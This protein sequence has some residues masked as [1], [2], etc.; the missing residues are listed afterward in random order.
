MLFGTGSIDQVA[1]RAP[2]VASLD[3]E[4]LTLPGVSLLRVT[5]EIARRDIQTFFP[6]ALQA[7]VPPLVTW[8]V[9]RCDEGPLGCFQLAET[10]LNCR[11]GA[12]TRTYLLGG[13]IDGEQ[14]ADVLS[15]RWGFDP[16]IG[17]IRLSKAFDR[18]DASVAIE[19]QRI[20]QVSMCDPMPLGNSAIHFA[21][22]MHPAHTPS[23][24]RLLQVDSTVQVH[25]SER[26]RAVVD[27]FH[28]SEWNERRVNPT[29]PVAATYS[30][31][32]LTLGPLRFMGRLDVNAFEG[33]EPVR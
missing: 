24:L 21:P 3:T 4:S 8:S 32:D 17:E 9:Y 18:V 16:R 11:S 1:E 14:A 29:K 5:F 20:L 12:R 2:R 22:S 7:T 10:Q 19:R 6:P 28:A 31:A 30:T 26:G 13:V 23:G 15:S 25:R 27:R 33:T